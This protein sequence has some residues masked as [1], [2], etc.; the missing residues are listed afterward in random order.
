MQAVQ[1]LR[2]SPSV[3]NTRACC[4]YALIPSRDTGC[5][6]R[7]FLAILSQA[8]VCTKVRSVWGFQSAQMHLDVAAKLSTIRATIG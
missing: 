5:L 7:R 6:T 1:Y 4:V 2:G 3:T 8:T